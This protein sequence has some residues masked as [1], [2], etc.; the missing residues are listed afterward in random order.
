MAVANAL[1][2]LRPA[3]YLEECPATDLVII[4]AG[5]L[6][7]LEVTLTLS[8]HVLRGGLVICNSCQHLWTSGVLGWSEGLSANIQTRL[9]W[10]ITPV[11]WETTLEAL[12]ILAI[13]DSKARL[14][15]GRVLA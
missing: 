8:W 4:V 11:P 14:K 3:L 1:L 15:A 5:V 9:V 7:L 12:N 2:V 13:A 10:M 6:A